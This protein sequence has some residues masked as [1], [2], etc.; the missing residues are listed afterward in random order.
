MPPARKNP[1]A[2]DSLAG[3]ASD[4]VRAIIEAAETS[5]AEIRAEAEADAERVRTSA[6]ERASAL[7]SEVRGD[8]QALLGSIRQA[9]DHLRSDLERLEARLGE[10]EAPVT[11][12]APEVAQPAQVSRSE[13]VGAPIEEDLDLEVA[14]DAAVES[15]SSSGAADGDREGARLVALN[16]ALEGKSRDEVDRYLRE[17]YDLADREG[18]LDE[19]YALVGD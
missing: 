6:E 19:V 11:A 16:L 12:P 10:P 2:K 14:E 18:L 17:N 13:P 9:V 15:P 5:A 8:V 3:A 1:A 4:R 7:R